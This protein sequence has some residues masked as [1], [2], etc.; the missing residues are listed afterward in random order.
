MLM[1]YVITTSIKYRCDRRVFRSLVNKKLRQR[2]N[3]WATTCCIEHSS[4]SC[5]STSADRDR[6]RDS[7]TENLNAIFTARCYA[8]AVLAMGLSVSVSVSVC[9]C[10][11]LEFY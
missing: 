9:V 3:F 7:P 2:A 10:H 5:P 1:M 11:K 6:Q 4:S 8:S